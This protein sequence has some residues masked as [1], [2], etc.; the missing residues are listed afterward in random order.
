MNY[1]EREK[2]RAKSDRNIKVT[3][4]DGKVIIDTSSLSNKKTKF[5]DILNLK[6]KIERNPSDGSKKYWITGPKIF[7][8]F[9]DG[10]TEDEAREKL[11]EMKKGK[12]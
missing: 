12:K 9:P 7:F 5:S 3:S 4:P 8:E 10:T 1:S 2:S 6:L 11:K